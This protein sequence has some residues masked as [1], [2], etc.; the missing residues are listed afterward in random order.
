METFRSALPRAKEDV[1]VHKP[2]ERLYR[3]LSRELRQAF[4]SL[5]RI[6][7]EEEEEEEERETSTRPWI[8]NVDGGSS[9][10]RDRNGLR[11]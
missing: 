8:R 7:E 6:Q 1:F 9:S 3:V 5:L 11:M 10:G 4:T 2:G